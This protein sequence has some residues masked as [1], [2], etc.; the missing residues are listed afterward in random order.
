[1]KLLIA[2]KFSD[3]AREHL[4]SKNCSIVYDP[5]LKEE[6][7][8]TALKEH[9]PAVLVVRSTKVTREMLESSALLSVVVRAGAGVNTIDVSGASELG[10]FVAN[11][12]GKNATAVAELAIGLMLSV[13]RNIPANVAAM[14]EGR[15]D[16]KTFSKAR[17]IKGN[18]LG[19]IGLGNIGRE[20]TARAQAFGMNV[21]AWS[22]SLTDE[23]A[24][25]LGIQRMQSPVDVA[26]NSDIVSV[27]VALTN[28]TKGLCDKDFFAA[29]R[30]NSY[31][32]NT[33]RA[34]V[35]DE[36]ALIAAMDERGIR[37]G[38]DV[39][40]D[41]PSSKTCDWQTK[42]S[43]HP[44][45]VGT[46]H[47]GASTSQAE[48]A[49][50][51]ETVRIIETFASSGEVLNCINME[52][53]SPA[54]HVLTIRHLNKVGV[55]AEVLKEIQAANINVLEMEN[56]IFSGE[57]AAIAKIQ[58]NACPDAQVLDRMNNKNSSVISISILEA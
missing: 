45:V 15:W 44:N 19:L 50:G 14:Q 49:I 52:Q 23:K 7:L 20:V 16:K 39:F 26:K 31:F 8:V 5:E 51:A 46:H 42:L 11:C 40:A 17:G 13:D 33:S 4:Q 29:M 53:E 43:S 38:L 47:I 30:D 9:Q 12:P 58:L 24:E 27:H 32:I 18:T 22:R 57:H 55:L 41:E 2:D 56:S 35:V 25:S 36:D 37:A 6:S 28:A 10:I 3:S 1:M 54:T 21:V 48:A 34:E